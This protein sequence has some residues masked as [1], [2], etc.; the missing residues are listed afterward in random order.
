MGSVARVR[1][2]WNERRSS[3]P[4]GFTLVE[5][6][7]TIAILGVL[8][9]MTSVALA[10]FDDAASAISCPS[11]TARLKRAES[12]FFRQQARYGSEAD[13]VG[14]G[15][16]EEPSDAH[17][18]TAGAMSY[19][20]TE[21]GRCVGSDT[22]YSLA[23]PTVG[24]STQAGVTVAV[25]NPDGTAVAGAVV[26]Y[27]QGAWTPMGSTDANGQ[28]N[29]ALADG[30]YD[31]RVVLR[32]TTNTLSGVAV[33]QGI[34]VT[35]PTV[36]LTV[37]LLDGAGA[38]LAGGAVSIVSSGGN[39]SSL[40]TTPG[41]GS[42]AAQ[43]LPAVYDVTMTY[44]GR[45]MTQT[46]IS[47]N[48]ATTVTFRTHTLTVR[49][50][51]DG[52]GAPLPGGVVTATPTGGTPYALGTTNG[53]GVVVA[54]LLGGPYTVS[55]TYNGVTTTQSVTLSA[56]ATVVFTAPTATLRMLA[57]TGTGLSGQDAA[58]WYRSAGATSWTFAG[59]PNAAGAVSFSSNAGSYD[60]RARW[61]GQYEIKLGVTISSGTVVTFQA[62]A[63]TEFMR[64]S[65]GGGLS[66]QDSAIWVRP[67]GTTSWFFS[68]YPNAS[69]Q[70]IQ[71]LFS[72]NYDF[73][74]RWFGTLEVQSAIVVNAPVT[75]TFQAVAATEFMRSST[76][77]GLS[78]QD[79]AIWVRPSGTTSWFFSG[80]PNASGQVIQELFS[81]TYDFRARWLGT[82]E[83]S[84]TTAI[85][86]PTTVTFQAAGVDVT[87]RRT[88]DN[89]PV[90]GA[91]V[92][93]ITGATSFTVGTTDVSGK[94]L[95]EVLV[96]TI[97]V[98]CTLSPITGTNSNL[99]VP[100]GGIST[101]VML[102]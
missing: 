89:S 57:S 44:A 6:L 69:G 39:A 38:P 23:A 29:A 96:S 64:S 49:L 13:L 62:V 5:L 98:R 100:S 83:I 101:T 91:T 60:F 28:V 32:G 14:A 90:S 99:V 54:T 68:G 19:S 1:A 80:Y 76:G 63:A 9:A 40:G 56:H 61:F 88:S 78:G 82:L 36:N 75:V 41:S 71:E 20:I 58:I 95:A 11:D 31:F 84:P 50:E 79:S 67:A 52:D 3:A 94:F 93:V 55:M 72:A 22:T 26:S 43:I 73:R 18:I 10:G 97:G 74:A 8:G 27:S 16:L 92:S 25:M 47:V 34:L 7:L 70:V 59:Y 102:A 66:G 46:G 42:V 65:T 85:A 51:S 86:G 24:S 37:D 17:D 2:C 21:V 33:T 45:S 48:A 4:R 12:T 87:A 53:S 15:L 35:F 77:G 81:A 30:N